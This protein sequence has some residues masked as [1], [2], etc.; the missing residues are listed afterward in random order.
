[1]KTIFSR[2]RLCQY[3]VGVV[4][5][6][7]V[8]TANAATNII[9]IIDTTG[10]TQFLIDDWKAEITS[11]ETLT[12]LKAVYPGARFGLVSHL[13]FPMNSHASPGEY[14]YK[15]EQQLT[16][17][18]ELFS[19]AVN[20]LTSGYGG[21]TPES[22][23]EA[24]YQTCS[25][26]GYDLNNNGSYLDNGDIPPSNMGFVKPLPATEMTLIFHFTSPLVYHNYP[27]DLNY[28][29]PGVVNRPATLSTVID[30]IENECNTRFF[31][32]VPA[33][34]PL[35]TMFASTYSFSALPFSYD[36]QTGDALNY[37][38]MRVDSRASENP[39][40]I[41]AEATDGDIKYVGPNL[42]DLDVA[43]REVMRTAA[44][45]ESPCDAGEKLIILPFGSYCVPI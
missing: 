26:A 5:C 42:E 25:G 1:M 9:Y 2:K 7:G 33:N 40:E 6:L 15:L 45:P 4:A 8:A 18:T 37:S 38:L 31:T 34:K 13:D 11:A 39:A 28:P 3:A 23:L 43:I 35:P 32:F 19:A 36:I 22:Q 21:D 10:S 20:G 44:D 30:T 27:E 24:I 14:A 41:L 12:E 17:N 29:D 16:T